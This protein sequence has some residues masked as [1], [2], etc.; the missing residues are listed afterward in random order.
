MKIR[1]LAG[2]PITI[3]SPDKREV[4]SSTLPRPTS[5]KSRL[6]PRS[7]GFFAL[8]L[9]GILAVRSGTRLP[10]FVIRGAGPVQQTQG[11]LRRVCFKV[12]S[13][14]LRE[15]REKNLDYDRH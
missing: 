4:D 13:P 9:S 2:L 7:R 8:F 12:V 10:R 11:T 6:G 1:Y 15:W 14:A 5:T 3:R